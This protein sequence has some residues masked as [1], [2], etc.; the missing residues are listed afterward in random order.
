MD[1]SLTCWQTAA[2]GRPASNT[3]SLHPNP[4]LKDGNRT[5]LQI[6]PA[7]IKAIMAPEDEYFP[8]LE[9]PTP[10]GDRY[11]YLRSKNATVLDSDM[12]ITYLF[13]L[14]LHQCVDILPRLLG[15][16]VETMLFLGPGNCALS[17]V[18]GRSD[19]GTYEVLKLLGKAVGTIGAHYF[20]TTNEVN[21]TAK[22]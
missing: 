18:E 9:C 12:R 4:A 17:V 13:A 20:L 1:V 8:R 22:G 6:A 5:L 2:E 15:S 19:D 21:P 14:D 11:D 7:Y 10:A 3:S 16:I